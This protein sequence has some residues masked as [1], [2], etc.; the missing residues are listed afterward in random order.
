MGK[1]K[2]DRRSP[3]LFVLS[4]ALFMFSPFTLASTMSGMIG[5]TAIQIKLGLDSIAQGHI[6]LDEIYSWH[7]GL[8]FT[9]HEAG[10]YLLMGAAYKLLGIAGVV[11]VG[12]IFTYL[13]AYFCLKY[14]SSASNPL[15]CAVVAALVPFL[16]G[17]PDYSVRPS[18][19]SL[20]ALAIFIYAYM[21]WEHKY[22]L[23]T[24]TAVSFVLGWL[25]GGILPVFAM[26]MGFFA[27]IELLY[28]EYRRALLDIGFIVVGFLV[29]LLN[30]IGV[31]V[32]TFGLKQSSASDVWQYVDE[33]KPMEFTIFSAVCL[34]VL[35]IGFM[36]S[37]KVKSFDKAAIT[38]L[39]LICMFFV[40][41]CVY[42]RFMLQLSIV[43]LMFA[44]E[45]LTDLVIWLNEHLLHVKK[46]PELSGQF[47]RLLAV[48]CLVLTVASGAV[49]GM[50]YFHTNTM[51]DIEA[52]N[53]YDRGVVD[54]A[55]AQGYSRP[56]NSFNT[57]SWLVFSG[58]PVHID[59][60]IDPYMEEYSG[61]DHVRGK[62][63]ISTLADLDYV[64]NQYDCDAYI[65]DMGAGYSY[66][67]YEIE[68][69]ASDRYQVVYDNT[70]TSP[71]DSSALRWVIIE[72]VR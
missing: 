61:V 8:V 35:F 62:M 44:P 49:I 41:T 68:T 65:L 28:R 40:A 71:Y 4:M 29:S 31:R 12:A 43:Y 56:F 5:D 51:A 6:I 55:L 46:A 26:V 7:E 15:V 18:C 70:V 60:R 39:G 32:W 9:A 45:Y 67:L 14:A 3:F 21:K 53:C 1:V 64:A 54:Y 57:G 17:F 47:Y 66:L 63:N 72:P 30:P 52:M 36:T 11:I 20:F 59:N 16:G 25:H 69:Y 22:A 19:T 42:K 10:W 38:K 50:Q 48:I 2:T 27:V 13:A 34:L 58:V 33:W 24:F 23:I 37:T